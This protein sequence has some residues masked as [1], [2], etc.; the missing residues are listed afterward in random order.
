VAI[1]NLKWQIG[2]CILVQDNEN[3]VIAVRNFIKELTKELVVAEP[4]RALAAE[5]CIQLIQVGL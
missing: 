5:S 4:M 2:V 1:D 3:C